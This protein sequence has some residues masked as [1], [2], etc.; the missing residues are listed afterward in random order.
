MRSPI[1]SAVTFFVS[2]TAQASNFLDCNLS[3]VKCL[4]PQQIPRIDVELA[5]TLSEH[6]GT[7]KF[8]FAIQ[9]E[10]TKCSTADGVDWRI[11]G[12]VCVVTAIVNQDRIAQIGA[13][14]SHGTFAGAK[15]IDI[16][17]R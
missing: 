14:I 5:R 11:N 17:D 8:T 6:L 4:G 7:K 2:L 10:K 3:P 15:V 13:V 16:K 1:L 12:G 9:W